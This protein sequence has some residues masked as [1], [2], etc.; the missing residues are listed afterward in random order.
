MPKL[1]KYFSYITFSSSNQTGIKVN[2]IWFWYLNTNRSRM[3]AFI[4]FHQ[5]NSLDYWVCDFF[6]CG[7][8]QNGTVCRDKGIYKSYKVYVQFIDAL[9]RSKDMK[10]FSSHYNVQ[11]QI[12]TDWGKIKN[13]QL[14]LSSN[15]NLKL[16]I[17]VN[18]VSLNFSTCR[19][20]LKYEYDKQKH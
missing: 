8:W 20:I 18:F 13:E 10:C 12:C 5:N 7:N 14:S 1:N 19:N 9:N 15:R 3:K 11:R 16:Y 6:L 4:F 2:T 17:L